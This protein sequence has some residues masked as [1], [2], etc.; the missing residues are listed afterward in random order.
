MEEGKLGRTRSSSSLASYAATPTRRR[1]PKLDKASAERRK[2]LRRKVEEARQNGDETFM[3]RLT[4]WPCLCCY[5]E[6]PDFQQENE[7]IHTGYR[8]GWTVREHFLSVLYPFH[9]ESVNIWTHLIGFVICICVT[10]GLAYEVRNPHF[11]DIVREGGETLRHLLDPISRWP[12]YIFLC[13]AMI[14]L[15]GSAF[16]HSLN[17][18]SRRSNYAL[19]RL[20]YM[21]IVALIASSFLPPIHYGF[22]CNPNWRLVYLT[23]IT[24]I[25]VSLAGLIFHRRFHSEKWRL[26]RVGLFTGMGV[27]GVAPLIHS[28]YLNHGI[29]LATRGAFQMILMGASYL[30]GVVFYAARVPERWL[31][32]KF[33][34]LFNSHQIW[35]VAVLLGVFNHYRASM[36]FVE[37]RETDRH[38]LLE[39]LQIV[40]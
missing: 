12:V 16:A 26:L 4:R 5:D 25:A 11:V 29:P 32:G 27:S 7:W 31:P 13:G 3:E 14:C 38:C 1:K 36:T 30:G 23:S 40:R 20:D 19:W 10:V 37:W 17:G 22:L 9:N 2:L 21:G 8:K 18:M 39:H 24:G 6:V 15:G 34:L 28:V 33:D 35:H